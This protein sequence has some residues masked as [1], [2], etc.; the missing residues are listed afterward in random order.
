MKQQKKKSI[1]MAIICEYCLHSKDNTQDRE[2]RVL[3]F[4]FYVI[5]CFYFQL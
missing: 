1:L 5:I 4:T 3:L 2:L